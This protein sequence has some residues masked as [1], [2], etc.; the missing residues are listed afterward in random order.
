MILYHNE[1]VELSRALLASLPEGVEVVDCTQAPPEGVPISAYPSVQLDNETIL[2][3]PESWEE[4]IK[5][6]DQST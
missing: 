4:V 2:R 6:N 1:N 5:L 3:M